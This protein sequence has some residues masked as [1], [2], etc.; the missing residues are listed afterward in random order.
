MVNIM[1]ITHS[2]SGIANTTTPPH[3]SA[4]HDLVMRR[5]NKGGDLDDGME[6][7]SV[8]IREPWY[9][10]PPA[11]PSDDDNDFQVSLTVS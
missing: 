6:I 4:H 11:R 8:T 7:S 5:R 3:T 9:Y 2:R 10:P 1:M